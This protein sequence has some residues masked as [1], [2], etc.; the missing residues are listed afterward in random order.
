MSTR[1][2]IYSILAVACIGTVVALAASAGGIR[3]LVSGFT[4]WAVLPY[5][6]L[7]IAAILA[8]T[9]GSMIAVLVVS[10]LEAASAVYGYGSLFV[11][12]QSS[13][14]ALIFLSLPFCQ[15]LAAIIVLTFAVERRRY[16]NDI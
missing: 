2:A 7:V 8:R 14:A 11:G 1:G 12:H 5:M 13:T 15:L 6:A 10:L 16:A 9:R 4:I 3:G